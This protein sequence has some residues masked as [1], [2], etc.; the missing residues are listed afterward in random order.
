[1]GTLKAILMDE[2]TTMRAIT[3]MA[4]E[5]A[6]KNKGVDDLC[7]VGIRRRGEPLAKLLQERIESIEGV[8]VPCAELDVRLFRD[9]RAPDAQTPEKP[10][11]P[12]DIVGK[13]VVLVDDVLFTGRTVRAAIEAI[14]SLGRPKA[15]QLA[16]LVDRGHRELPF[17]ADFVGKNIPTALSETI[18]VR[19][20]SVDSETGVWLYEK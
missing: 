19:L 14:F 7:L 9:D 17:R 15:I 18:S 12:F 3:R 13:K 11:L 5:I 10:Q 2:A 8:L 20:P 4:H 1:M 6:E 16:I